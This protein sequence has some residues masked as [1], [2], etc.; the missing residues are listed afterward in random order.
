MPKPRKLPKVRCTAISKRS[1][2][3]CKS[4]PMT[5]YPVCC[6]HNTALDEARRF[7]SH[8]QARTA[9]AL[10]PHERYPRLRET[11]EKQVEAKAQAIVGAAIES[12]Q[13]TSLTVDREGAEHIHVDYLTRLRGADTLM[14]RV[15]GKP[16]SEQTVHADVRGVVIG[17]DGADPETRQMVSKLLGRRLVTSPEPAAGLHPVSSLSNG[18]VFAGQIE[19]A[20]V[21]EP[22]SRQPRDGGGG[23]AGHGQKESGLGRDGAAAAPRTQPHSQS[24]EFEPDDGDSNGAG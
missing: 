13:A 22:D 4:A 23:V 17:I 6:A 5:G 21:Q 9:S 16:A 8:A 3:Q 7:G 1:G 2:E 18:P 19:R 11:I 10:A 20:S 12:L 15:L 14:Q 24:P